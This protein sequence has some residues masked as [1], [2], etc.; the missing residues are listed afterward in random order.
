MSRLCLRV[1][2]RRERERERESAEAGSGC[3]VARAGPPRVS[4]VTCTEFPLPRLPSTR[5]PFPYNPL[6]SLTQAGAATLHPAHR[7]PPQDGTRLPQ[8]RARAVPGH[9]ARPRARRVRA[10]HPARNA[11]RRRARGRCC[12]SRQGQGQGGVGRRRER[13]ERR[14]RCHRRPRPALGRGRHGGQ[15]RDVQGFQEALAVDEPHRDGARTGRQGGEARP[16]ELE[17]GRLRL[18]A[19]A[20]PVPDSRPRTLY[21]KGQRK[22]GRGRR[23][24]HRRARLR[25][26]LQRQRGILDQGEFPFLSL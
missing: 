6:H 5:K 22:G 25:Q 1:S 8:A 16:H 23:V 9:K 12:F 11:P 21:G 17:D 14:R 4:R 26:V 24:P 7:A 19:R 2:A 15:G 13:D 3:R 10:A 20:V 18:Q